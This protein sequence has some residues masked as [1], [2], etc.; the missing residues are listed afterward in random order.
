MLPYVAIAL[1]LAGCGSQAA[2]RGSSKPS[3]D[4]PGERLSKQPSAT[5]FRFFAPS[6]FWNSEVPATAAPDPESP[7]VVQELTAQVIAEEQAKDG[8]WINTTPYGIPIY[9]V[10]AEQPKTTVHLVD[11]RH[12]RSL[13]A[14]WR[15]VP[16]PATAM[17]AVGTDADLFLWQPSTDRLWEFW[18][19]KHT[20][21]GWRAVWGGAM[22]DVQS[23]P[24][25]YGRDSWPGAEPTWGVSASSLSLVGGVISLEDLHD[26]Q[27][28]HALAMAVPEVRRG[29]YA[30]P[31]RRTDGRSLLPDSLP[32][33]AH[34]RLNPSLDL[35]SLHLAPLTLEIAR[36]AQRYGIIVTDSSPI[37]EIYAQDPPPTGSDPYTAPNG[38]FE[39]EYPN[40][41]LAS[42]PWE[43]LELLE[44][45]LH[46]ARQLN[47]PRTQAGP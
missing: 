20:T 38:Y 43:Q 4:P 40:Q 1:T 31:A 23:S 9:T 39:G 16:L 12:H 45:D 8:P 7:A 15:S 18:R 3:G 17:P 10:P 19:L 24:G 29:V 26:G 35:E 36:A 25:V 6:S 11:P 46:A 44:M 5:P 13:A 30:S 2:L 22:R 28:D 14:A 33:G 27:I 32:E 34:L 47:Y 37:V 21:A 41:L 42:F